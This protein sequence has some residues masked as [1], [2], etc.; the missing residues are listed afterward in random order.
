MDYNSYINSLYTKW[1]NGK[2]LSIQEKMDIIVYQLNDPF[3]QEIIKRD[4]PNY[5]VEVLA[6]SIPI[7]VSLNPDSPFR[8]I[9]LQLKNPRFFHSELMTHKNFSRN[10]KSS[11]AIPIKAEIN[12][13]LENPAIPI[14]WGKNQSGMQAKE[15]LE[16]RD[17]SEA[18]AR[19]LEAMDKSI[20][21]ALHMDKLGVHK[22]TVNRIL[23]P[24]QLM[25]VVFTGNY[26][27]YLDMLM[28][29]LHKAAQPEFIK[30]AYMIFEEIVKAEK[31]KNTNY[32]LPYMDLELRTLLMQDVLTIEDVKNICMARCARVSYKSFDGSVS[33][34]KDLE[35]VN[36]LIDVAPPHAS[37][38][39][40]VAE[41]GELNVQY[42]NL[43]SWINC[44]TERGI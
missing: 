30:L 37:A 19:W 17:L 1:K 32:H 38:A 23:E 11:R 27:S 20:S 8:L 5:S 6:D 9:T 25:E 16:G 21:M 34:E 36:K 7:G 39:E 31:L 24:Y 22:Q 15:E 26:E 28:L 2:T 14:F 4:S 10:A 33:Y 3:V 13:I 41:A 35:L 42:A 12:R 44:R 18:K 29:R 43:N 40:H